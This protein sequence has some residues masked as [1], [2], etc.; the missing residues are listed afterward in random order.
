LKEQLLKHA[1]DISALDGQIKKQMDATDINKAIMDRA[2][3]RIPGSGD[4]QNYFAELYESLRNQLV[5]FELA[6]KQIEERLQLET[7]AGKSPR[8]IGMLLT[9]QNQLFLSLSGKAS[10]LHQ[11][12]Q[13]L[14]PQGTKNN[15]TNVI[16]PINPTSACALP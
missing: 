5:G 9:S 8:D 13:S 1:Q 16:R 2:S 14:L 12:V 15:S 6:I 7:A 11:Q 3:R 4:H 10:E